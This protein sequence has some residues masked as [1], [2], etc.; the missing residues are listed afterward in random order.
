MQSP[1]THVA[2]VGLSKQILTFS[3]FFLLW[4]LWNN[5]CNSAEMMENKHFSCSVIK[6]LMDLS[7]FSKCG[8]IALLNQDVTCKDSKCISLNCRRNFSFCV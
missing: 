1:L 8:N 6:L 2:M 3:S 7:E 5:I 4:P